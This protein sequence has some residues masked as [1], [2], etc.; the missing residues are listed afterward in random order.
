MYNV[1]YKLFSVSCNP[2]R[3]FVLDGDVEIRVIHIEMPHGSGRSNLKDWTKNKRGIIRITNKGH[4]CLARALVTA[5]A[6]IDKD[7]DASVKWNNIRQGRSEQERLAKEL[8]ERAGVPEGPC[9]LEEVE[10]FQAVLPDYQV[11]T[12]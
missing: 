3:L 11:S 4:L 8:H 1:F 7:T 6:R 12:S 5:K 2:I 10:R 9:G